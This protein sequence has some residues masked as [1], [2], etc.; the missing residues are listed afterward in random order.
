MNIDQIQYYFER[1]KEYERIYQKPERQEDLK[2]LK[3]IL[4]DANQVIFKLFISIS[5][6]EIFMGLLAI[7]AT[8]QVLIDQNQLTRDHR[9]RPKQ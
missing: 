4:R 3:I 9:S 2:K 5:R 1:A 6:L 8:K 7:I